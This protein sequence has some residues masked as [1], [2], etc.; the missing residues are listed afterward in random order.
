MSAR[1]RGVKGS[2]WL[3]SFLPMAE[4]G[5]VNDRLDTHLDVLVLV[6]VVKRLQEQSCDRGTFVNLTPKSG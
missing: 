6:E 3:T 4:S 2:Y 1:G 5:Q